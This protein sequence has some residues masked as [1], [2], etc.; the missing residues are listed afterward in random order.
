M[1]EASIPITQPI[2]EQFVANYLR[3][4]GCTIEKEEQKWEV[5]VPAGVDTKLLSEN[6]TLICGHEDNVSNDDAKL[7]YPE[8]PFFQ[9]LLTEASQR[10]PA[11]KISLP[12]EST[13]VE[14]PN[15]LRGGDVDVADTQ[16]TPY[17]DRSA[18]VILFKTSVETVSEYQREFLRAV[19][20]D[21][22]SGTHLP[23]LEQTFLSVT[24][25]GESPIS[26]ASLS[27]DQA[28]VNPRLDEARTL[29]VDRSQPLIDEIHQEASR[30]ADA[31]L[32]E[33]RQMQQQRIQ[34]LEK[35][36]AS[37]SAKIDELSNK[38]D[39]AQQSE[40]VEALK[41]RKEARSKIKDVNGTVEDLRR[42]RNRGF[43]ERQR[44][45]RERH[46]LEV[47]VAPLTITEVEYERGEVEIELVDGD[48]LRN[49]TVGYGSGVG[50]TEKVRCCS[51]GREFTKQN[52]LWRIRTGLQCQDC[53][54]A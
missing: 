45:I 10:I 29:L 36:H 12:S 18:I 17:Y 40:R 19:G 7:L 8:S 3:S 44:D 30:A 5:G 33:Y 41:A 47:R 2:V 54:S 15:W 23:K 6:T 35:K 16:F 42:Q 28:D 39:S 32:E 25:I 31:E 38:I 11:G 48:T 49:I 50:V 34:E 1:T 24:S 51:C 53:G 22:R 27:L 9:E 43:P 37:L 46:A 4:I 20:L 14:L 26:S 52:P 21:V 13:T